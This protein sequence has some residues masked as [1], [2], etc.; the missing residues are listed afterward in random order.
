MWPFKRVIK[1][2]SNVTGKLDNIASELT[3][4][5]GN[6]LATL[7]KQGDQQIVL[8]GKS[9]E[10]LQEMQLDNREILTHLRDRN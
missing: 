5:R 1:A 10:V 3:T 6:C 9:V 8:L 2:Y 7:Q 4:Q